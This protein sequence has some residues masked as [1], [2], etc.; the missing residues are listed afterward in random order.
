LKA[1]F[2]LEEI[3]E[4][5]QKPA[6]YL[7]GE[8]NA[9]KKNPEVV[10]TKVALVFPDLYEVGMSYLGQKILYSILNAQP[11]ILAERVF[12]PWKDME[13]ELRARDIPLFSLENRIPLDR[14]DII[15]FSL[16]YELNYTN[17][18]NILDLGKVSPF[19]QDRDFI[20]PLVIAGGPAA[21][22]PEPLARLFDLFLIGD[23]EEAF[24][25]MLLLYLNLK[26]ESKDKDAVLAEM[27]GIKGVY[28]PSLYTPCRSS[29]S[30]LLSI[31]PKGK[32]PATIKKRVLYPFRE[33]ALPETLV[34]PHFQV[35]FDRIAAEVSRGCPQSCRFCQASSIYFPF[36]VKSPATVIKGILNSLQS[37]GYKDVSMASLSVSDYPYLEEVIDSL[38]EELEKQ[39]VSIS[40]SSL[41]PKGLTSEVVKNIV[42]VRKTGFTLVPEAGTERLRAVINKNLQDEEIKEAA[43]IAFGAGWQRLKLY[44]MVGLPTETDEDLEAIVAMVKEILALG[45]SILRKFP[46]INL[47]LSS[48]I[49][50]PHTPFQ[51][52]QMEQKQVLEEKRRYVTSRLKRCSS[53]RWNMDPVEKSFL[54]GIFSRG[55]RRLS[56]VLYEA[57]KK[58]ARFDSWKDEFKFSVWESAFESENIDSQDYLSALD[59]DLVLPWD[60]IDTGI[61]KKH[62]LEEF[63][64]ALKGIASPSCGERKC[65]ECR[66][67]TLSKFFETKFAEDVPRIK[68]DSPLLGIRT[69]KVHRYRAFYRKEGRARFL[70]QI[71]L[72][73]VLQQGFRRAGIPVSYSEGFHP[74]MMIS[75]LPALPL[76]MEGK[77]ECLEFKSSHIIQEEDFLSRINDHLPDGIEFNNL[78]ILQDSEPS[79]NKRIRAFIYSL[80]LTDKK[81]KSSVE[82]LCPEKESG[83][84]YF[85]CLE[86]LIGVYLKS[87]PHGTLE[88]IS[89]DRE[90]QKLY[91]QIRHGAG[92]SLRAQDIIAE[93]FG[94]QNPA[95]RMAREKFLLEG[96]RASSTDGRKKPFFSEV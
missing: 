12:A 43:K 13:Q 27:A 92:K 45:K 55:D 40:L 7:G 88:E 1:K 34:V 35:I 52:S 11:G 76:G 75:Y 37:T 63:D 15:G 2:D 25:E 93:I 29:K 4:Y 30:S 31:L 78:K 49:P 96:E 20:K 19:S 77:N 91:L 89:L 38:M 94:L 10:K 32:A 73:N 71:D 66:G 14:F 82:N 80:D 50:K 46:G 54:E 3:L 62:L 69:A 56:G 21:F 60:H 5:V 17:V 65:E 8:W 41:R 48:F 59:P 24:L 39:K 84:K 51:W 22:N 61:K 53:V 42:R 74:K 47:S 9:V 23:G 6:R 87:G 26:D 64:L 95:F 57:W 18:V 86:R 70:S 67:C 90:G 85:S 28:V 81:I 44:F 58:G 79:V 68:R 16:L 72:N 33:V 83:E 36:R